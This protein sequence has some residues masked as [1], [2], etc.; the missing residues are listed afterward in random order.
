MT[1]FIVE[2]Y[3][4]GNGKPIF[5]IKTDCGFSK[6]SWNICDGINKW[7]SNCNVSAK[8]GRGL[9]NAKENILK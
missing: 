2:S 9:N 3:E 1:S 8:I 7:P 6:I 4:G 5:E